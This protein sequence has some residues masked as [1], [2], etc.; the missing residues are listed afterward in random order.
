MKTATR[1]WVAKAE[2][3]LII[4]ESLLQQRSPAVNDGICF[5]AQQ[6]AEKYLKAILQELDVRFDRTHNLV[7]LLNQIV[8]HV[9]EWEHLR[10]DLA[11]LSQ[12]AVAFR[13]PGRTADRR[14]ARRAFR[15]L[16]RIRAAVRLRLALP[17]RRGAVVEARQAGR[18]RPA[19]KSQIVRSKRKST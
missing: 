5:H 2:G 3:D 18:R 6:C 15:Q 19:A 11:E 4:A 12:F 14:L 7:A 17:H 9:P 10:P 13:Y 8:P 16:M 1:K